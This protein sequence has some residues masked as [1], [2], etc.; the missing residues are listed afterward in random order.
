[1]FHLQ[2]FLDPLVWL[3]TLVS[4]TA[5]RD[6]VSSVFFDIP[7]GRPRGASEAI[8]CGVRAVGR[9]AQ[10]AGMGEK[11]FSRAVIFERMWRGGNGNSDSS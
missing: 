2:E 8:G 5:R 9:W 1:V 7:G 10:Q 3:R 11:S 6:P 4:D